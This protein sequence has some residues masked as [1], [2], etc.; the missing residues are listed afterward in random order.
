MSAASVVAYGLY[1]IEQIERVEVT[2]SQA[3]PGSPENFLVV[4]SD[5]RDTLDGSGLAE[6]A[7]VGEG[8]EGSGQRSDTIMV[9]RVDPAQESVDVLSLPRDL[10]LPIAGTERSQRINTAYAGGPQRLVDTI[11]TNFDIPVHH[12]VEVDFAGFAGLVSAIGGV[13]IWFDT[14]MRDTHSGLRIESS[15]CHVL[16]SEMAL[17]FARSRHLEYRTDDGWSVDGTGDLGR[18]TRQQVFIR[19]SLDKVSQMGVGDAVTLNRLADVAIDNVTLDDGLGLDS[20]LELGR[21]FATFQGEALRTYALPVY[22]YRTS[23]GA[24]VLGLEE[25][26]A[27]PI[28]NIFRGLPVDA[29]SPVQVEHVTVLN[30]TG[31]TGQ[32]GL[33]ADA[34]AE[35]G[36]GTEGV[37]DVEAGLLDRTRIRFAPGAEAHADLLERHLTAG[38]DLYLD[39]SLDEGEVV[40]E[41]GSDLTTISRRPRPPVERGPATTTTTEAAA[42]S[43]DSTTPTTETSQTTTTEVQETTTSTTEPVGVAP[44]PSTACA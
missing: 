34:L 24:S 23:G 28:L 2:L 5:T 32:A 18:I 6:G 19:R 31:E 12:Y 1:R 4:G 39:P 29:L 3:P 35:V 40:L 38:A 10:W 44:D 11:E 8:A 42:A 26:E 14:P 16:D 21:R 17:A 43:T 22:S 13:P 33:V 9:V 25:A 27:Q 20:L 7:F 41:T 36:F 37:G 15:G 30:G